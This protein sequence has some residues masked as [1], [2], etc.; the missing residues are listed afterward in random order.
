LSLPPEVH[1]K[2]KLLEMK[3]KRLVNS[4]FAGTYHSAFKGQGMTF[5]DFREYVPGDDV[6]AI[7]WPLTARTGKVYIKKYEEERELN[8]MLVVDISGSLDFGTQ[9]Y[10]KG[11]VAAHLSALL[12]FAAAKNNDNVGLL[13]VTDQVEHYVPPKKGRGHIQRLLTDLYYFKQ[14]SRGTNLSVGL[15]YLRG[16]LKKRSI[17]FVFSDFLDSGYSSALRYLSKR[18]ET[19]A[20]II[21]DPAEMEMSPLGMMDLYDP[22][23]GEIV[24]VDTTSPVV[25]RS[26]VEHIAKLKAAREAELKRAQVERIDVTVGEDFVDPLIAYFKRKVR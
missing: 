13:L 24:T 20:V 15:E 21:N 9:S 4:G 17:V 25:R 6:R 22:E 11:E 8:L 19:V 1:K 2:I 5:A 12:G 23:T 7:S 10:L 26:Y 18:H 14:K 16:I 3:T